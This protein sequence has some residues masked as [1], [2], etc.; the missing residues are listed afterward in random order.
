M[1]SLKIKQ[2]AC[3]LPKTRTYARFKVRRS[4]CL[5]YNGSVREASRTG[6]GP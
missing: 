6:L 4:N 1:G 3:T 2:I 5:Q